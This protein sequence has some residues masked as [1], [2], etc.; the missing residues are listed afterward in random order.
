M[1]WMD[2]SATCD[3][4][5]KEKVTVND[6]SFCADCAYCW[7][8]GQEESVR[9]HESRPIC[10]DCMDHYLGNVPSRDPILEF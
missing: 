8:C 3:S 4:C 6:R 5:G 9:I 7:V 2:Y 10:G 1:K